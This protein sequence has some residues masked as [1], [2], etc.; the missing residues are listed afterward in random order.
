MFDLKFYR[1]LINI[2]EYFVKYKNYNKDYNTT[3]NILNEIDVMTSI[4]PLNFRMYITDYLDYFNMFKKSI[5]QCYK[6]LY[7]KK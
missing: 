2:I 3:K 5:C 7:K 1:P 4:Y 6:R